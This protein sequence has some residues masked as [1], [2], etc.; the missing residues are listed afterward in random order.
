MATWPTC[1]QIGHIITPVLGVPHAQRGEKNQKWLAG[2]HV[3]DVATPP[4]AS[5]GS[6]MLTAG[7]KK[8]IWLPGQLVGKVA[9][10]PLPSWVSRTMIAGTKNR[11]G[12]L[13]HMRPNWL[14]HPCQLGGP[15]RS[16][17][18]EKTEMATWPKCGQSGYITPTNLE[19]P[20]AQHRDKKHKW[21]TGPYV[22]NRAT[23]PLPS[24]GCPTLSAGTKNRNGE[25]AHMGTKWLHHPCR[26][27]GPQSSAR[28]QKSEMATCPTR[29]LRDYI[30]P[31][32]LEFP[33]A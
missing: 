3:G 23:I 28:G 20:N 25:L 6:P 19:V 31:A 1:G 2:P 14:N 24:R 15:Q 8:Q 16:A 27:G 29:G 7:T 9:T 26:L 13:A 30:T 32:V 12:Y 10:C 17:V 22:G 5:W 4:L 18:G 21:L 33:N 11:N